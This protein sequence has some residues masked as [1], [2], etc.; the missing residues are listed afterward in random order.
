MSKLEKLIEKILQ[1]RN[2]SYDDAEKILLK[3]GFDVEVCGSHH[4]FR[5]K[6]YIKN[7]SIKRRTQL[8]PYQLR[9]LK[10]V[11]RDHGY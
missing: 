10:E 6:G 5:K 3:L 11:L 2:I 8:L 4:V 1:G 7:V 9:E